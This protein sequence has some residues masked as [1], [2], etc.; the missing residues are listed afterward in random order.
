LMIFVLSM[1]FKLIDV[2]IIEAIV[3]NL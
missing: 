1:L 2:L 3:Y